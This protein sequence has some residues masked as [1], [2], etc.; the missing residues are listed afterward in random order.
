[1]KLA[2]A[3]ANLFGVPVKGP[4][5]A[6]GVSESAKETPMKLAVTAAEA[7]LSE[8]ADTVRFIFETHDGFIISGDS[9]AVLLG[10]VPDNY[11]IKAL[12]SGITAEDDAPAVPVDPPENEPEPVTTTD[13]E[14]EAEETE[15]ETDAEEVL[16]EVYDNLSSVLLNAVNTNSKTKLWGE[17]FDRAFKA[18]DL[19]GMLLAAESLAVAAGYTLEIK[20]DE[21]SRPRGLQMLK[22]GGVKP[23]NRAM[24]KC[25]FA[26]HKGSKHEGIDTVS[27]LIESVEVPLTEASLDL[28]RAAD[29]A[30]AHALEHNTPENHKKAAELHRTAAK[31]YL[32][33]G[34]KFYGNAHNVQAASHDKMA[35]GKKDEASGAGTTPS[36]ISIP[37]DH[38][39]GNKAFGEPEA[40]KIASQWHGGQ[41][42]KLYSL[43]STGKVLP[44]VEVEIK[45]NIGDAKADGK[46]DLSKLLNYVKVHMT[47]Q[48]GATEKGI[49]KSE[50]IEDWIKEARALD[51]E[52]EFPQFFRESA[53]KDSEAL[54]RKKINAM[55][56]VYHNGPGKKDM[57]RKITVVQQIAK[58]K[59]GKGIALERVNTTFT[60]VMVTFPKPRLKEFANKAKTCG[61]GTDC[62]VEIV[63]E[64]FQLNLP[65]T[66]ADRLNLIFNGEGVVFKPV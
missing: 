56:E 40:R 17:A 3:V 34:N 45:Q 52:D 1:M 20:I 31:D 25:S 37:N 16:K 60:E 38:K 51:V 54:F 27:S 32:K 10:D 48:A 33:C 26:M 8:N 11:A 22:H 55:V 63:G 30:T 49:P 9:H 28:G 14:P 61:A 29:K 23:M 21:A 46:A 42:S 19:A 65:R 36:K 47:Q 12:P 6:N 18:K 57:A 53:E 4:Y 35:S 15:N 62:D 39:G 58:G 59:L 2:K 24:R 66:V 50:S 7:V 41:S 5:K 13:D 43:A 44:G 64:S